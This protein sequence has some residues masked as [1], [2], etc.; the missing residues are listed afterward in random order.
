MQGKRERHKNT[1]LAERERQRPVYTVT[2]DDF[3]NRAEYDVLDVHCQTNCVLNVDTSAIIVRHT[4]NSVVL[5]MELDTGSAISMIPVDKVKVCSQLQPS[6]KVLR[7]FTGESVYV[8]PDS[9]HILFGRDWLKAIKLDWTEIKF[10]SGSG[11][12]CLSHDCRLDGLVSK[13]QDLF[14]GQLRLLK[15]IKAHVELVE[16]AK[17]VYTKPYRVPYALCPKVELELGKLEKAGVVTPVTSSDWATGVVVMPKKNG[18]IRLC[19]NYKTTVNSQLKTV[20]PPN[21]NIDDILADLAG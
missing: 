20:S 10:R 4:V 2:V 7:S 18:A 12:V 15:G 21:I 17:P 6:N 19:G 13:H 8:V 16:G 5:P 1:E 11:S 14:D 9:R 3:S